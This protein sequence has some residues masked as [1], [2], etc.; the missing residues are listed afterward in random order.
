MKKN[1]RDEPALAG[2]LKTRAQTYDGCQTSAVS[3]NMDTLPNNVLGLIAECLPWKGDLQGFMCVCQRF[4]AAAVP[5]S[6]RRRSQLIRLFRNW[7]ARTISRQ[8]TLLPTMLATRSHQNCIDAVL[9][10]KDY[11]MFLRCFWS[12][13]APTLSS[14][15]Q[16]LIACQLKLRALAVLRSLGDF[17]QLIR[18]GDISKYLE[19]MQTLDVQSKKRIIPVCMSALADLY[20]VQLQ[21]M[22]IMSPLFPSDLFPAF[23]LHD[24]VGSEVTR[25]LL[26]FWE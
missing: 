26:G 11:T 16:S 5:V 20:L 25:C 13:F 3:R 21:C 9:E 18:D 8:G 24:T 15:Q 17:G 6:I 4:R 23:V 10:C 7:S 12:A 19:L 14:R 2:S 1:E 22:Y